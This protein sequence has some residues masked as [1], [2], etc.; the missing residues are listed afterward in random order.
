MNTL[1]SLTSFN[2]LDNYSRQLPFCAF[3][4]N[5]SGF[6]L[7]GK[8]SALTMNVARVVKDRLLIAFSWSV[9]K[10]TVTPINLFGYG[11]A[12]FWVLLT[13]TMPSYRL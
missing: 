2:F 7:V 12:H 10:D 9:I 8:T 13:I 1:S 5:L 3:A 6:L 11:V 4:L